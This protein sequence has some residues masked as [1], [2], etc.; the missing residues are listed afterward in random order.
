[1][2]RRQYLIDCKGDLTRSRCDNCGESGWDKPLFIVISEVFPFF[3]CKDCVALMDKYKGL[4]V[5]EILGRRHQILIDNSNA[6]IQCMF[7]C[8]RCNK[9]QRGDYPGDCHFCSRK[10]ECLD[11]K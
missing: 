5:R 7:Q 11:I 2:D 3:F 9:M 6:P 10:I 8:S 1:L 4:T